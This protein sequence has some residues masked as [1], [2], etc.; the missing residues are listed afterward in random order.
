MPRFDDGS[1]CFF[2][3]GWGATL[4]VHCVLSFTKM[5]CYILLYYIISH[6]IILY[7][8]ALYHILNNLYYMFCFSIIFY[9][10]ILY[11]VIVCF[12][13]LYYIRLNYIICWRVQ[14]PIVEVKL[15]RICSSLNSRITQHNVM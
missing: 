8:I 15:Q 5:L 6:Y 12:I 10:I 13:L 2:G 4:I 7:Y 14:L 3:A 9:H 11:Y 1:L